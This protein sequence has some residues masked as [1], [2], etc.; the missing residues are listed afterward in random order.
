MGQ[1]STVYFTILKINTYLHLG[2]KILTYS[3]HLKIIALLLM[4]KLSSPTKST[5]R[6]N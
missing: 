5:G 3:I 2:Y 4:E 6:S 1:V